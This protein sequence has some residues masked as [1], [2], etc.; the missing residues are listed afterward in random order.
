MMT[1]S[2]SSVRSG[3]CPARDEL[4]AFQHG[5][6]STP[7]LERLAGHL[8]ECDSC[9]AALAELSES[10]PLFGLGDSPAA[11]L[12]DE[13]AYRMLEERVR[14]ID[15][16]GAG[17]LTG[18]VEATAPG[19]GRTGAEQPLDKFGNYD[20]LE[21]VG[22]GGMG[23]VYRARQRPL[24]R[25]VALKMLPP[26][27][28]TEAKARFL[29]EGQAVARLEHPGVV[30]IHEWGE[31]QGRLYFSMEFVTG[32]TLAK[33]LGHGAL[34]V[35]AAAELV[36]ALAQAVQAAHAAGV[37]HRDLKPSNVLL[38]P[39]GSP[40]VADFG[41]A[42]LLDDSAARTHTHAVVG[43]AQYMA[44]E[45]AAGRARE[46]GP[47][48]DVYALG[49]ILY[50]CLTG[51]PPFCADS[52]SKVLEL[53][54]KAEPERPSRLREGLSRDLEAVCLKC[55]EKRPQDRYGSAGEL[56]EDLHRWLKGEPT[57]ARPA[58]WVRRSWRF[59][60]RHPRLT[61]A[62]LL[63]IL[64][65]LAPAARRRPDPDLVL[66]E[67]RDKLARGESVTLIGPTGGPA[68]SR[69][70]CSPEASWIDAPP[71]Q[72]VTA[73]SW[74]RGML[75]LLPEPG[76]ERYRLRASVRHLLAHRAD[77]VGLYFA[78]YRQSTSP[79]AVDC[80]GQLVFDDLTDPVAVHRAANPGKEF[81][82]P[83][84]ITTARLFPHLST[85]TVEARGWEAPGGGLATR[86]FTPALHDA[87]WH[88]LAVEVTPEGVRGFFDG[89]EMIGRVG[90]K[91]QYGLTAAQFVANATN[92]VGR[93]ADKEPGITFARE[94]QVAFAPGGGLGLWVFRGSV[95]YRDVVV[96]PLPQS[97]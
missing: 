82:E 14:R 53:V 81:P 9:A 21:Q 60:R 44:P 19:Y 33:L 74:G 43:T 79:G 6:L 20:L 61:V 76:I 25:P 29:V 24:N 95:S 64:L 41:L 57:H 36:T 18:S 56:A 1:A 87:P 58:G 83:D 38:T 59:V 48:A 35:S 4:V 92:T 86:P 66:G 10:G 88:D 28:S 47:P 78:R 5:R 3:A 65:G 54:Q 69:W 17:P 23:V 51:R 90:G 85:L 11:L 50:E 77:G 26:G 32:G 67:M 80:Y 42:K 70:V 22:E 49:C 2:L 91:M 72:P 16:E 73:H 31:H 63:L 93:I 46:V 37:V 62:A 8:S 89:Q 52:R 12:V 34:G 27:A 97:N 71:D 7:D 40:K 13:P 55:L 68:W 15:V 75:E 30:R 84:R 39:D 96:E 45:Q 94:L